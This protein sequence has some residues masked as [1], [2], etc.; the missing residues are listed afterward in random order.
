MKAFNRRLG[1]LEATDSDHAKSL[2]EILPDG[3]TDAELARIQRAGR[4]VYRL[5]EFL[6]HCV[7]A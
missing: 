3:A 7:V 4:K 1:A 2:P 6:N 5:S